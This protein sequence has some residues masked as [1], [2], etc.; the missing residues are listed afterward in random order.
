MINLKDYICE[1]LD[2]M[3]KEAYPHNYAREKTKLKDGTKVYWGSASSMASCFFPGKGKINKA[4]ASGY[5]D[6]ITKSLSDKLKLKTDKLYYTDRFG[7]KNY[8]ISIT[9]RIHIISEAAS[10]AAASKDD[11]V[12]DFLV[13][14]A[15]TFSGDDLKLADENKIKSMVAKY[16]GL[17]DNNVLIAKEQNEWVKQDDSNE[18]C[19]SIYLYCWSYFKR[20]QFEKF[21]SQF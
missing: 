16:Y 11:N 8:T 2:E 9:T 4:E 6:D 17:E 20:N 10:K 1:T 12:Q 19:E 3:D 7:R 5:C 13:V 14:N 18:K 15:F 21:I